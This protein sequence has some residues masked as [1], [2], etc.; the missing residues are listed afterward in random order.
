M[1]Q[2]GTAC[3]QRDL[4]VEESRTVAVTKM[5]CIAAQLRSLPALAGDAV[6]WSANDDCPA[7]APQRFLPSSIGRELQVLCSH[8]IHHYALIAFI[9]AAQG[10]RVKED[11]GVAPSTIRHRSQ[12]AKLAGEAA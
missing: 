12:M 4:L 6:I 3:A 7:D 9:L 5:Y 10:I 8:T 11:L 1:C 2:Y